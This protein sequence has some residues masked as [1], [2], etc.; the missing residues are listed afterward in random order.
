MLWLLYHNIIGQQAFSFVWG[1]RGGVGGRKKEEQ[2]K[3]LASDD[4]GGAA[5][6]VRV[7]VTGVVCYLV[8]EFVFVVF[9]TDS[10]PPSSP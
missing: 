8:G 4:R 3:T 7:R 1:G 2:K 6:D 9:L 5:F 10:S